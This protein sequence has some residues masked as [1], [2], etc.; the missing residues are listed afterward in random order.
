MVGASTDQPVMDPAD[1]NLPNIPTP[2]VDRLFHQAYAELKKLAVLHLAGESNETLDATALVH[3]AYMRI[4]GG[5]LPEFSNNRHFFL[6]ASQAMR[7]ILIDRARK[8]RAQRRGG[9]WT[10]VELDD[11]AWSYSASPE[12]LLALDEALEQLSEVDA[13][14]AK[15]VELRY[16]AGLSTE[17]ASEVLSV[18]RATAYRNWTF[19]K[20][21]LYRFMEP[22]NDA[23]PPESG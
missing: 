3:E 13:D 21:W 10:R 11:E 12:K 7:R 14:A 4:V 20:A 18:S 5:S 17:Q 8:K 22:P 9:E 23:N 15:L 2:D 1:E 16:F 6:A 19:A